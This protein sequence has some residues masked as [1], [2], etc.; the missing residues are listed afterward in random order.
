MRDAFHT[1]LDT[2]SDDL[3][4]MS[5]SVAAAIRSAS[6]SLLRSD[7]DQARRVVAAD[8][9]INAFQYSIDDRVVELMTQHQP[10]A[11]DLRF[12]LGS[13]R[14]AIDLERMGDMAKH[15]AKI[16]ART[17]C[18]MPGVR[19]VFAGMADVANRIADKTTAILRTRDRLDAAQLDLDDDEMDA[20]FARLMAL[21]GDGWRHG[22]ETAVDVAMLGR[23]YERFA[24]HAVRIAQQIVYQVTGEVHL[25]RRP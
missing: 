20:L 14:V 25:D 9:D 1:D 23:S 18:R 21:L 6:E 3:V 17:G 2:L 12:I 10:M 15:V 22:T 5:R 4:E 13:M 7:E 24:D 16:G 8:T 19:D 11:S